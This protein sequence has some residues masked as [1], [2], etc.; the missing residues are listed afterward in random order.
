VAN[1][2]GRLPLTFPRALA[3]LP[4]AGNPAAWPGDADRIVYAEKLLLGY[5]W[6]DAR[7]I[8]PRFAFGHGLSYGGRFRYADATTT[9]NAV[10]FTVAN[11]GTRTA[12]DVPQVYAELPD[13]AGEPPRR[14]VGWRK[15]RLK[16]GERRRITVRFTDRDLAIW[17][18]GWKVVPGDYRLRI[19]ASS[20]DLRVTVP[21]R[22]P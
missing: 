11:A 3:D 1:P 15:V 9:G 7:G 10:T 14:L 6:F 22:R 12:S 16:P 8:V 20:R 2:S 4:T 13:A 21:F 5:R 18:G 17:D 19:G